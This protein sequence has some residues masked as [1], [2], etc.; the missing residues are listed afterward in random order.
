MSQSFLPPSKEHMQMRVCPRFRPFLKTD[1]ECRNG[2]DKP[3]TSVAFHKV[4]RKVF[5]NSQT[6]SPSL[7]MNHNNKHIP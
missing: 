4:G 2:E 1:E 3:K 7:S 6:H 5:E